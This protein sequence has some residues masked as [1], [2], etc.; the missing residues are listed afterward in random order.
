M[1]KI[2]DMQQ[3]R[4]INLFSKI[5]GVEPKS[6]F[7]YA[8]QLVFVVPYKFVSKAIGKDAINAKK[9]SSIIGKKVKVIADPNRENENQIFDFIKSLIEPI[10]VTKIE[11][12]G[13][14]LLISATRMVKANLIGRNKY[15]EKQLNKILKDF[16]NMNLKF[17]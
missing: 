11:I 10:E 4:Y 14:D 15:K 8:G 13:S 9:V 6:S 5:S 2:I 1:A 3:M 7:I 16:L 12:K 17:I